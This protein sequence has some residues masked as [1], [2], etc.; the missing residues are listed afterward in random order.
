MLDMRYRNREGWGRGSKMY[1]SVHTRPRVHPQNHAN[2]TKHNRLG[3]TVGNKEECHGRKE[4]EKQ[5]VTRKPRTMK[6]M[7]ASS[8]L[9]LGLRYLTK[10]PK[11]TVLLLLGFRLL[12]FTEMRSCCIPLVSLKLMAIL[13]PHLECITI[14][15]FQVHIVITICFCLLGQGPA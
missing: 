15:R 3:R 14:P 9:C 5:K 7:L 10:F 1:Y 13:F 11:F 4:K 2:S 6:R 8:A 12:C